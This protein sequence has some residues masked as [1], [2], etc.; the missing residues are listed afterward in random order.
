M[1]GNKIIFVRF[2]RQHTSGDSL[3]QIF[4]IGISK[5]RKERDR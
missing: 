4:E 3:R 2:N 5:F 1:G